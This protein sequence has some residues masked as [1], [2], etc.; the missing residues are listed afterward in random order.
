MRLRN[1]P[2]LE[3]CQTARNA[4]ASIGEINAITDEL[5]RAAKKLELFELSFSVAF[6]RT[7]GKAS[8][9]SVLS[10]RSTTRVCEARLV[11]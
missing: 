8:A 10:N 2:V 4:G 1:V 5:T 7:I 3:R 9:A 6:K 11:A